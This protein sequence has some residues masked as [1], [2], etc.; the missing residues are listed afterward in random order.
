MPNLRDE[1]AIETLLTTTQIN[2]DFG[3]QPV[4]YISTTEASTTLV[5]VGT[6]ACESIINS[7]LRY[8]DYDFHKNDHEDVQ[9]YFVV[10]GDFIIVF[11]KKK[12]MFKSDWLINLSVTGVQFMI[13]YGLEMI[14][15][16]LLLSTKIFYRELI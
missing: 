11:N 3:Y 8:K 4:P 1:N 6:D 5:R 2:T 15:E 7:I 14:S 12:K 10:H 16:R 9:I 13:D